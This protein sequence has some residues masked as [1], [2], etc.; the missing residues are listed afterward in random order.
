[1]MPQ[2]DVC[3]L[4]TDFLLKAT[5]AGCDEVLPPELES[6]LHE[7]QACR[8]QFA[9]VGLAPQAVGLDETALFNRIRSESERINRVYRRAAG[10]IQVREP[11]RQSLPSRSALAACF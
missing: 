1:M 5:L 4:T 10:Q 7:C 6:H 9:L 2:N 8:Q 3:D 11:F